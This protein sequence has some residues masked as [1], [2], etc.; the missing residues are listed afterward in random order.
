MPDTA[1]PLIAED[2]VDEQLFNVTKLIADRYDDAHSSS[3]PLIVSYPDSA[4]A[5]SA[6]APSVPV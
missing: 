1:A 3:I 6:P 2:R 4:A 5:A